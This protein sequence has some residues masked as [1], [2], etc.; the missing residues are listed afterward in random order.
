MNKSDSIAQLADAL[1]KA[2]GQIR[3]A[4]KD[5]ANPFFK[6]KYADLASV[7]DACRNELSTNGLSVV[8]IPEVGPSGISLHTVLMHSSGE[9]IHGELVMSP[10]KDDPQGVGSVITYARRYALSSFVGIAPEDDDGNAASQRPDH[11]GGTVKRSFGQK[12][13]EPVIQRREEVADAGATQSAETIEPNQAAN[14]HVSF[15]NAL[16]KP[17]QPKADELLEGWLKKKGY[18]DADGKPTALRIPKAIFYD[19][20]NDAEQYAKAI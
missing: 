14:L 11:N 15:K 13:S 4:S 9:W 19:E 10:V 1:S 12:P 18:I 16:K 7:W 3:N 6:S 17:L 5:S 2:Q 20:R 8:Q